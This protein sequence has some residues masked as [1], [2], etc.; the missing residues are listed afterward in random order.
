M[1]GPGLDKSDLT[2]GTGGFNSGM[3][4]RDKWL[5]Y[6]VDQLRVATNPKLEYELTNHEGPAES[7]IKNVGL[8]GRVEKQRP[9]TFFINTQD[10]WFTTNGAEKGDRL[11]PIEE[12]GVIKRNDIPQRQILEK[13]ETTVETKR[14]PVLETT[15]EIKKPPVLETTVGLE[16]ITDFTFDE[17][18]KGNND[19]KLDEVEVD[20][21]EV[22]ENITLEIEDL[23]D[24]S[25]K[26][27]QDMSKLKEI[28]LPN[29]LDNLESITLK[30]PNQVYYEIYQKA[31]EKAKHAKQAAILAYLEVK[32]IK[33]TYMLNDINDSDEEFSM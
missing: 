4:A 6:T 19:D 18:I 24:N 30:K 12:M 8:L 2:N 3:E 17:D 21:D 9:D 5:P 1:V 31:R 7:T 22:E 33:K 16:E 28:D 32:N 10:R 20:E 15:V 11:R 29:S 25:K 13:V 26:D 14:P 23:N 27:E